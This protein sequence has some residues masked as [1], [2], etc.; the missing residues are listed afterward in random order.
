MKKLID[1][2]R[3]YPLIANAMRIM[4]HARRHP[5]EAALLNPED[6]K[7]LEK[8]RMELRPVAE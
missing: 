5:T 4:I 2:Y 3:K 1:Q 6:A 7:I 8:A